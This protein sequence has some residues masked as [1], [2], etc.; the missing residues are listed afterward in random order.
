MLYEI[1][2]LEFYINSRTGC[3]NSLFFLLM[4]DISLYGYSII[5]LV[6]HLLYL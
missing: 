1:P 4:S 5:Y 3:I 6:I 2:F